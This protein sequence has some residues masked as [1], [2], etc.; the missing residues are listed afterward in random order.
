MKTST[1]IFLVLFALTSVAS[2]VLFPHLSAAVKFENAKL[3]FD[4]SPLGYTAL[5][6]VVLS[7]LFGNVLYFKFLKTLSLNKVLFFSTLPLTIMYGI[8]LYCVAYL[9]NLNNA[10]ANSVKT[11]LNITTKNHYNSVLWAVLLT[12]LYILLL[13]IIYFVVTKPLYKMEKLLERLGQGRIKEK[14]FRLG[15]G[16]QFAHI[17]HSLLKIN[18]KFDEGEEEG[19][20]KIPKALNKFANKMEIEKLQNKQLVSR[21]GYLSLCVIQDVGASGLKGNYQTLK[22][23]MEAAQPLIKRFNGLGVDNCSFGCL[24]VF[25]RSQD[26]LDFSHAV[27]RAVKIKAKRIGCK[28]NCFV[29]V[30][31]HKVCCLLNKNG[32]LLVN[33]EDTVALSQMI[34][35]SKKADCCLIF[36]NAVLDALP[37]NYFLKYRFIGALTGQNVNCF[38]SLEVYNRHKRFLLDKNKQVFEKGV[39]FFYQGQQQRAK[40]IFEN[41]LKENPNDKAAILY[42]NQ[43]EN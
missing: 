12:I 23:Y 4:F 24:G 42:L 14:K 33:E 43:C 32:K 20:Q 6:L 3:S 15:G 9:T 19:L 17:G 39:Q 26:A 35:F 28:I 40:L 18:R 1:K 8:S 29:A 13:F 36:S 31:G 41:L 34:D 11:L 2:V 22:L 16:K 37:E 21:Y 10:F 30:D 5:G 38:E 27:C 25:F 7:N